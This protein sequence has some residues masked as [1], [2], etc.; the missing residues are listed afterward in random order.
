MKNTVL[1]RLLRSKST[2]SSYSKRAASSARR[3]RQRRLISES[4]EAR[5]LL[6]AD[7]VSSLVDYV[8]TEH[9]DLNLMYDS[10][11]WSLGP[12]NSDAS[13]ATQY[14]NDE[15]VLYGGLPS[16]TTRQAGAAFDFMGVDAGEP[17][18]VLPAPQNPELLYLGFAAYGLDSDVAQYD[19]SAES[20]GRVSGN[21]RWA[22]M[23]LVGLEHYTPE[24]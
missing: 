16:E 6:A 10:G 22:K 1:Q 11:E 18:Y 21:Y 8:T 19:P 14:G 17:I 7:S 2:R 20:K 4:L 23:S 12:R 9:V 15:A 5:Q 24:G 3:S 13:P